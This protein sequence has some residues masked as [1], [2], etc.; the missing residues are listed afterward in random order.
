MPVGFI[1]IGMPDAAQQLLIKVPGD[2]LQA[3]RHAGSIEARRNRQRRI[4]GKV[5][6]PGKPQEPALVF[7]VADRIDADLL[8]RRRPR[9]TQQQIDILEQREQTSAKCEAA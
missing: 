9:G 3:Q 4:A 1:L 6:G 8:G 5:V 7:D 2:K